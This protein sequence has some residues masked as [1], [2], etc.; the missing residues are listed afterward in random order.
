VVCFF[1]EYY[2]FDHDTQ[3]CRIVKKVTAVHCWIWGSY[4]CGYEEFSLMEYH[5]IPFN[6]VKVDRRFGGT[7]CLRLHDLGAIQTRNQLFRSLTVS[8]KEIT[9]KQVASR[10]DCFVPVSVWL[11]VR[12]WRWKR[13][14]PPNHRLTFTGL[15]VFISLMIELLIRVLLVKKFPSFR[16]TE[17]SL[18]VSKSLGLDSILSQMNPLF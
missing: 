12:L 17:N 3:W 2:I 8:Q 10:A 1:K 14:V 11:T 7:Y 4:S 13:Y 16:E 6:P 5:T 15:H 9:I 18:P